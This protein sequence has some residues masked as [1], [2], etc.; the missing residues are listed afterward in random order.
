[1]SE[2]DKQGPALPVPVREPAECPRAGWCTEL[3]M[4]FQAYLTRPMCT[5]W[6]ARVR[7]ITGE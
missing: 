3:A 5:D 7:E 6:P 2:F 4:C 1:M